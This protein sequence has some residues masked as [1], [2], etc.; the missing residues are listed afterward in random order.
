MSAK[1]TVA[2]D[3]RIA[4]SVAAKLNDVVITSSPGP[5]CSAS[6]AATSDTVP[7][8]TATA[9]GTPCRSAKPSSSFFTTGP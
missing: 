2:P 8:D 5:I 7:F 9:C 4:L 6:S 3:S 1:R